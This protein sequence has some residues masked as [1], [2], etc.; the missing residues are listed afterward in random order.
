MKLASSLGRAFS[1]EFS[2]GAFPG[3]SPQAGME[4]GLW[5]SR[6]GQTVGLLPG[7][8]RF[9]NVFESIPKD[10][11]PDSKGFQG[12]FQSDLG[13]FQSFPMNSNPFFKKTFKWIQMKSKRF[14]WNQMLSNP[15]KP[16]QSR[17][18]KNYEHSLE[19]SRAEAETR[20][21]GGGDA[22]AGEFYDMFITTFWLLRSG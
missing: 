1:P 18:K 4:A 8:G 20:A 15:F 10:S 16:I 5:P 22:L 3:A 14:K 2:F 6:L 7:W 12:S 21:G 17:F 11:K 19:R 9:P 13:R